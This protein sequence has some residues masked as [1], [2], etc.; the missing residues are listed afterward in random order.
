GIAE[1]LNVLLAQYIRALVLLGL[2]ASISYGVFFSI[3]GVPYALLLAAIAFPL[4]FIP[5]LGPAASATIILIVA[6]LGGFHNWI[7][8]VAFLAVYRI[9]Q[10][11]VIAP[12][13]M[14]TG[15]ELHPLLVIFGVFA[16]EQ[17]GGVAGAFLS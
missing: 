12:H 16:G 13:L 15:M 3:I 2:S 4:E 5:M 9:L 1:D 8:L 11:Y 6:G 7:A 17:I 10:D 14:S